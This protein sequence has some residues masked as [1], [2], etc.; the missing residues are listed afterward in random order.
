MPDY[1]DLHLH[2]TCSDGALTPV[3]LA[4]LAAQA[5]LRA[6]ALADHDN[7][8]GIVVLRSAAADLGLEVLSGVEL[9]V[10]WRDWRDIHLLGY[11]FNP[12][13]PPL[14]AALQEF[15]LFRASRNQQIVARVNERLLEAG[16]QEINFSRVRELA[17]GTI[18]RPHIALALHEAGLVK[19]VEEAFKTYLVAC[20]V[21]KRYFPISEAIDLLHSAGGVAV[22]AHPTFITRDREA[23][24]ALLDEL[25]ELGLDG[26]EVYSSGCTRQDSDW[27]LTEARRRDL[28]VTGGSDF[29]GL[30]GEAPV[31]GSGG[32]QRI[33]Y[34]CVEEI[35][36][37]AAR[38]SV[39]RPAR[40]GRP[41]G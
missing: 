39:R 7:L 19:S 21:P 23:F 31:I 37:R 14:V 32:G 8:D 16:H 1:V 33:P 9:S 41:G 29:H 28:L 3:E 22:L 38:Y 36:Q 6:I 30:P 10:V 13:H 4:P 12:A 18:G 20:N 11:A 35:H 5:G 27:Y 15:Q 34:R 24:R 17:E 2:S 26:L 40:V 25:V